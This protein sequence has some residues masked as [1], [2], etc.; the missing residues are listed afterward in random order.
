[1]D[2][3]KYLSNHDV[4]FESLTDN[5]CHVLPLG[6]GTMG[7]VVQTM[8]YG[9]KLLV[10]RADVLG[11][12]SYTDVKAEGVEHPLHHSNCC[13]WM[14]IEF[15][16]NVFPKNTFQGLEYYNGLGTISGG[17]IEIKIIA[18]NDA[19]VMVFHVKDARA[20]E[21]RQPVRLRLRMMRPPLVQSGPRPLTAKSEVG[22]SG[23]GIFLT[24]VYHEPGI[25]GIPGSEHYC[26][27]AVMLS[28]KG[29]KVSGQRIENNDER[30]IELVTEAAGEYNIFLSSFATLDKGQD[31]T[32]PAG[33]AMEKT[34][35][36][37]FNTLLTDQEKW[38]SDFW[39]KSFV[40][41]RSKNGRAEFLERGWV[42]W[43]YSMA[44][45]S[46][47]WYVPHWNVLLWR[48]DGDYEASWSGPRM[49][50][51]NLQSHYEAIPG[52][53]HIELMK[54]YINS[55]W[56]GV[57]NGR[58]HARNIRGSKGTYLSETQFWNG[59]R[60]Y[61]NVGEDI[62]SEEREFLFHRKSWDELS[63]KYKNFIRNFSG[64]D[65]TLWGY[66]FHK[67][68]NK[69]IEPYVY[70]SHCFSTGAKVAW[71]FFLVWEYTR[72]ITF[73][74]ER[75]YPLIRDM[76]EFYRNYPDVK[77]EKDGKYHIHN[78]HSHEPVWGGQDT[79]EELCGMKT[80]A[81]LA[82]KLARFLQT[83]EA[84]QPLWKDLADNCAPVP[85]TKNPE[86][87]TPY[88]EREPE[89]W[90]QGLK[91]YSFIRGMESATPVRQWEFY[92]LAT[93]ETGDPEL[94]K[95]AMATLEPEPWFQALNKGEA[96]F[97]LS[98]IPTIAMMM[99]LSEK[100]LNW[101]PKQLSG[102]GW[103][104]AVRVQESNLQGSNCVCITME[105]LGYSAY[106]TQ[107]ALLQSVAPAPGLEPVIRVFPAWPVEW[108]AA[109]R[110]AA[111]RG[112][113]V[114]SVIKDGKVR[115]VEINSSL[116]EMCRIRNPWGNEKISV[117][118]VQEENDWEKQFSLSSD[119]VEF[120]TSKGDSYII[121]PGRESPEEIRNDFN[122]DLS[123][124]ANAYREWK[125]E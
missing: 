103:R 97:C 27:S 80:M 3:K 92:D 94:R 123:L 23:N 11:C 93:L 89:R 35:G 71:R 37:S 16:D 115:F 82:W 41:L 54:P 32:L 40:C 21:K 122:I 8:H 64:Y 15:G 88:G 101:L 125:P 75:A 102:V 59:M 26:S 57:E 52:S 96:T 95:L 56:M 47:S 28:V 38:W 73:L 114:S 49:W 13:G 69:K 100:T 109:F 110:L 39:G 48:H 63:E 7:G 9:I 116:G 120:N 12:N 98:E 20:G 58:W 22:S 119:L 117:F 10:N 46:R 44:C 78:V 70:H 65:E 112:F 53:N 62:L 124:N 84:L 43:L 81:T 18:C 4:S 91:P 33:T 2:Y 30:T 104:D 113:T 107:L 29:D 55:Y 68:L 66:D 50:G 19:D 34:S 24:Q 67:R 111:R 121:L 72:D 51:W 74:K 105:G 17:G 76:A 86:A 108:D 83:D 79:M 14:E 85:T 118:K 36:K 106:N 31:V 99:G 60:T 5:V 6:N 61:Q 90:V 77:K 45:C 1:M 25:P 87:I 42:A